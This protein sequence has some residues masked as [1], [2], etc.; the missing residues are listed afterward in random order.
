[1]SA[2]CTKFSAVE[3]L[4]MNLLGSAWTSHG[5]R[6]WKQSARVFIVDLKAAVLKP[7]R[8]EIIRLV[9]SFVFRRRTMYDLLIGRRSEMRESKSISCL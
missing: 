4:K 6:S 8:A 1:M 2:T 5:T 9:G 3:R 7:D